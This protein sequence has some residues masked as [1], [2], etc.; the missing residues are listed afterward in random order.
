MPAQ[1]L[2]NRRFAFVAAM[3]SQL[4]QLPPPGFPCPVPRSAACTPLPVAEMSPSTTHNCA[5]SES[6]HNPPDLSSCRALALLPVAGC[7]PASPLSPLPP[8]PRGAQSS[9]LQCFP[10]PP[11]LRYAL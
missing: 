5:I 7:L 11:I 8:I 10:S 4:R 3:V 9:R 1:L 6:I 2:G